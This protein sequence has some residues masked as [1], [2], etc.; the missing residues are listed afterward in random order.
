MLACIAV[1]ALAQTAEPVSVNA[2][3]LRQLY[4]EGRWPEVIRFAQTIRTPSADMAFYYGSA[5]AQLGRWD[6]ARGVFLA[7]RRSYLADKRFPIELAGV[8]F[9]QKKYTQ[10]VVWLHAALAIDDRD[11]Y[12]NDFLA[13]VYFLQG[14]L[15]AALEYWNRVGK[16]QIA[17]VRLDPEPSINPALLDS[18]FAFSSGSVL[19]RSDL[20]K[21]C[22]RVEGLQV[23]PRFA[24]DLGA[25]EDGRFDITFRADERDGWG[26][27][28]WQGLLSFFRGAFQQTLYPEFFNINHSGINVL[29]ML[30]WDSEKRRATGS[31]S[32]PWR[33]NAQWRYRL[34]ADLRNENWDIRRS[35]SGPAPVLGA[36]NL[37]REAVSTE[38][39]SFVN[40]R[41]MWST[42]AELSHR[43]FRDVFL[44][45]TLAPLLLSQGYQLKHIAESTYDLLRL[46]ER[47]FVLRAGASSQI[48]RIW[49]QPSHSFMK[50]Q[51]SIQTHWFPQ[52]R[53]D[54]YEMNARL[55][56]GKTF[57]QAP[58]DE[59]FMLGLEQ[60]NN[61]RLRAHIGT[62]D[63]RKGSA[64]LG[65]NY[66]LTNWEIDK[67][68]YK[69]GF[70]TVHLGPFLD[71]GKITD[72]S[73]TLG[74]RLWLWDT[75]LQAKVRVLG[76]GVNFSYGKDL[77]SGANA[78]Y[79]T[80]AR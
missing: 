58:F 23:F 42:G 34:G 76:V 62:R 70:F 46:P 31:V 51:G 78:F 77:R 6:D 69:N 12:A 14:N 48:G 5:L 28:K 35:F 47:R 3:A 24:F 75:G 30:R 68:V 2:S 19:S 36:L 38:I 54:D 7:G 74:S 66:F 44:G 50:L 53:G 56:A 79:V 55:G 49:S 41:W 21:S 57:G 10:A 13:T 9:K 29:S 65:R 27:N 64:P 20:L 33:Q 52:S 39:S 4:E 61:L 45:S 71:T 18:A 1:P 37:R 72:P 59:L 67:N 26:K 60:D 25:R 43:D 73:G 40:A 11:S 22:N 16:P 80:L 17:T 8:E 63:G 32:G 15:E